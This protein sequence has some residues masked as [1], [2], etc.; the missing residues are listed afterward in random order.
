MTQDRLLPEPELKPA[1]ITYEEFL[2]LIPE[3]FEW[4]QGFLFDPPDRREVRLR[5]LAVLLRNEGLV[6]AVQLA[7]PE[8]WQEALRR[9]YEAK[10]KDKI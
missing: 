3:K 4:V 10:L 1:P 6:R 9:A 8:R 7:P 5:L 2:A